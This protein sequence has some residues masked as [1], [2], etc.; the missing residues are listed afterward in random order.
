M[1]G[2]EH[3]TRLPIL[4]IVLMLV[5]AAGLVFGTVGAPFVLIAVQEAREV[6]RRRECENNLKQLRLALHNYHQSYSPKQGEVGKTYTNP[7]GDTPIHMGDPFVLQ[8]GGR[9]YLFGTNAPNEGFKCL[10]SADLVHWTPKGWAYQET[11]DSWAKS[12]YW[13]PEV[14]EYRGKFYMTYSAMPK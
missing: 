3:G 14:K 9:Y 7:V 5:G 4:L 1:A 13:A 11:D 2:K 12:H 6:A 10:E 8:H